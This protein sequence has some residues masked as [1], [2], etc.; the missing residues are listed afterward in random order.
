MKSKEY[1]DRHSGPLWQ[2]Y[3]IAISIFVV[4]FA[5]IFWWGAISA[6]RA[7]H[8]QYGENP[9]KVEFTT[10]TG[11][12]GSMMVR[13]LDKAQEEVEAQIKSDWAFIKA[14][15]GIEIHPEGV[16]PKVTIVK[17]TPVE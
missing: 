16:F 10:S 13:D 3:C 11:G 9:G 8:Q 6:D 7:W 2:E 14:V 5:A 12:S 4:S 1:V 15:K 17:K